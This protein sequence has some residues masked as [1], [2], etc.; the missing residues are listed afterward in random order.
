MVFVFPFS[1]CWFFLFCFSS[2][3]LRG[4]R[5]GGG[6]WVTPEYW[7]SVWQHDSVDRKSGLWE[8]KRKGGEGGKE[9]KGEGRRKGARDNMIYVTNINCYIAR[10]R[11]DAIRGVRSG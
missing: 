9:S 8:K 4:R 2:S 3:I 10:L 7:Y 1:Y 6:G 11:C 5:G